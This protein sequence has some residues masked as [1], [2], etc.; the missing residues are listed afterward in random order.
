MIGNNRI[1]ISIKQM[2]SVLSVAGAMRALGA[3]TLLCKP[4]QL[5]SRGFMLSIGST[6]LYTT[7]GGMV[8]VDISKKGNDHGQ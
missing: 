1:L 6:Q 8:M 5:F 4:L 2:S 7:P 3:G